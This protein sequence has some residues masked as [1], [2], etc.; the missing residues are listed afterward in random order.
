VKKEHWGSIDLPLEMEP[1]EWQGYY[2]A[3]GSTAATAWPTANAATEAAKGHA[4]RTSYWWVWLGFWQIEDVLHDELAFSQMFISHI[5]ARNARVEEDLVDQLFN[6]TEKR[7]ARLLLLLASQLWKRRPTGANSRQDRSGDARR[8]DRHDAVSRQ[9]LHEQTAENC[10][11]GSGIV[12]FAQQ[13]NIV[14]YGQETLEQPASITLAIQ[15][16]V[17]I[18][19]PEAACEKYTFIRRQAVFRFCRIVPPDQSTDEKL[20]LDGLYSASHARILRRQKSDGRD[21]Q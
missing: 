21:K 20:A 7:L 15:Q 6:S 12:L 1:R 13:S 3:T 2:G 8:D 9:S 4:L 10:L 16:H 14:A 17:G 19:Q 18:H 5:L 11:A